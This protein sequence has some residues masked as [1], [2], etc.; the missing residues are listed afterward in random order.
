M[1]LLYPL[2]RLTL[3]WRVLFILLWIGG[4][5]IGGPVGE[6]FS[7][8]VSPFEV[9]SLGQLDR[10]AW[11]WLWR[12]T[13]AVPA[14][15]GVIGAWLTTELRMGLYTWTL[16]RLRERLTTNLV[17]LAVVTSLPVPILIARMGDPNAGVAAF[18]LGLFAFGAI[19]R[20]VDAALTHL[21]SLVAEGTLIVL[22]Y[23][24]GVVGDAVLARPL[25][26]GLA[27]LAAAITCFVFE[28][29]PATAR[30]RVLAQRQNPWQLP[31]FLRRGSDQEVEAPERMWELPLARATTLTWV[32]A[33]FYETYG[34]APARYSLLMTVL[35]VGMFGFLSSSMEGMGPAAAQRFLVNQALLLVPLSYLM[36]PPVLGR[37]FLYPLSRPRRA[38][39]AFWGTLAGAA[40]AIAL[41]IGAMTIGT[42]ISPYIPA[43]NITWTGVRLAA[44][45]S[46]VL[47]AWVPVLTWCHLR[48]ARRRGRNPMPTVSW[49]TMAVLIGAGVPALM[50]A[51]DLGGLGRS[52]NPAVLAAL[53]VS[54]IVAVQ[55]LYWRLLRRFFATADLVWTTGE[56]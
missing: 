39:V 29:I 51:T 5:I 4:L 56:V 42:L 14:V 10:N 41:I 7:N 31:Q 44:K 3:R 55:V 36:R 1:R 24:G 8:P 12:L 11:V 38:I 26:I 17:V 16:P 49:V 21:P 46:P 6:L 32:R 48:Y 45:E 25:L 18:A 34:R 22:A 9:T 19:C 33:A 27:A 35:T 47:F 20:I 50:L 53:T 23:R 13:L 28:Y 54:L 2:A 43:L 30:A 37:S 40:V 52:W 15:F